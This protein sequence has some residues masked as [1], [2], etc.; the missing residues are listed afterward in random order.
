M[1]PLPVA[2]RRRRPAT[3]HVRKRWEEDPD[4]RPG[5]ESAV[6]AFVTWCYDQREARSWSQEQA[7]CA[8]GIRTQTLRDIE[9]RRALPDFPTM[10]RLA[11]I[12][13]RHLTLA[14]I[15]PEEM[16]HGRRSTVPNPGAFPLQP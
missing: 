2:D 11:H 5:V 6:G 3:P 4:I 13:G 10:Y 14:L 8:A 16:G 7:A 9:N 15:S 1:E 12:Y